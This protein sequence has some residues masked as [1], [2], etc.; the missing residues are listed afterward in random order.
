MFAN[1]VDIGGAIG[2][3]RETLGL[4]NRRLGDRSGFLNRDGAYV[5]EIERRIFEGP[6]LGRSY[7]F[8][9]TYN[10]HSKV[11][12]SFSSNDPS[13]SVYLFDD[14][15]M[16][17]YSSDRRKWTEPIPANFD[18][19]LSGMGSWRGKSICREKVEGR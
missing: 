9:L 16:W 15:Q 7:L 17:N 11:L 6:E 4:L 2:T 14:R 18:N 5:T 3:V 13:F 10:D 1:Q 19:V 8:A 12:L